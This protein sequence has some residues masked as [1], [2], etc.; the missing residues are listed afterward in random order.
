[1]LHVL[2]V[3]IL[4][5]PPK[6]RENSQRVD[7]VSKWRTFILAYTRKPISDPRK[8]DDPTEILFRVLMNIINFADKLSKDKIS[9]KKYYS[10]I[11]IFF[12]LSFVNLRSTLTVR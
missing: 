10:M 6:R 8:L 11:N 12:Y 3:L 1:M 9:K 7:I 5:L 2:S 4:K